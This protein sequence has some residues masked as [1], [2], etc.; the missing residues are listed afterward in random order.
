LAV[1]IARISMGAHFLTDV[2]MSCIIMGAVGVVGVWLFYFNPKFFNLI[3]R[4][5]TTSD[6]GVFASED[7][8][9]G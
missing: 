7:S 4:L 6:G 5:I 8:Y 2:T 3:W 9:E 1:A